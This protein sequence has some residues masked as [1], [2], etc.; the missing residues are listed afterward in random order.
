MDDVTAGGER[1]DALYVGYDA[2][3]S[4]RE[5]RRGLTPRA[6][7]FSDAGRLGGGVRVTDNARACNKML[8]VSR[9]YS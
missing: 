2:R 9:L 3:V 1:C 5:Q 6:F 4:E 7:I 8:N